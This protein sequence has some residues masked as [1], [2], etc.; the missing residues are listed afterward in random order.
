MELG[1][2]E[3]K[4][5]KKI[6]CFNC[7]KLGHYARNCRAPKRQNPNNRPQMNNIEEAAN[8]QDYDQYEYEEAA[9][10]TTKN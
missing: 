7:N 5:L 9:T 2:I 8:E 10:G 3:D 4:K 1:N 6:R